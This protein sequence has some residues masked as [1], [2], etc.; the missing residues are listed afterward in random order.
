M[1]AHGETIG[2]LQ[3]LCGHKTKDDIEAALKDQ[4]TH[5]RLAMAAAGQIAFRFPIFGFA[6]RSVSKPFGILSPVYI[7][8]GFYK[9]RCTR[10]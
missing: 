6:I 10:S 9:R 3:I 4:D 5:Q 7:T 1:V 8:A 2:V